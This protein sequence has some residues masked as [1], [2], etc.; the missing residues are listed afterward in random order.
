MLTD[1]YSSFRY[2]LCQDGQAGTDDLDPSLLKLEVNTWRLVMALY[3]SVSP[4]EVL[5]NNAPAPTI[6]FVCVAAVV[7]MRQAVDPI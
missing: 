3:R 4:V 2:R 5:K 6:Y 7:L 1:C